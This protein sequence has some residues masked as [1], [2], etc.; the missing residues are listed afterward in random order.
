MQFIVKNPAEGNWTLEISVAPSS[1]SRPSIRAA[2]GAAGGLRPAARTLRLAESA[3]NDQ[4]DE[5]G[6]IDYQVVV[7]TRGEKTE[8]RSYPLILLIV[9]SSCALLAAAIFLFFNRRVKAS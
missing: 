8:V 1:G 7:S 2:G 6:D 4:D 9:T 5:E 3:E